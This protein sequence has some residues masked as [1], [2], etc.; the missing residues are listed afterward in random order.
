MSRQSRLCPTNK[1]CIS[2]STSKNIQT[3]QTLNQFTVALKMKPNHD[4]LSTAEP[5]FAQVGR[6]HKQK[7]GGT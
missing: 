7:A 1:L 5:D 2:I 6:K 3:A 4:T